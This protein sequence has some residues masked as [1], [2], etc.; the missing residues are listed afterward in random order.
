M[1]VD[2]SYVNKHEFK[3]LIADLPKPKLALN[4]VGGDTAT[5]MTRLL[6]YV[7]HSTNSFT[8][9]TLTFTSFTFTIPSPFAISF[10]IFSQFKLT[11]NSRGGTMVTYGGMS[12]K[13]VTV[14]SSAFIFNDVNLRVC[15]LFFLLSFIIYIYMYSTLWFIMALFLALLFLLL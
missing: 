9:F 13:P 15:F 2:D 12:L 10:F 7:F 6:A 1:V 4:C 14:P 8:P 5:Q 11:L 3:E